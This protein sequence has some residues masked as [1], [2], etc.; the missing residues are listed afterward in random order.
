MYNEGRL[1][2]STLLSSSF[3]T[4]EASKQLPHMDKKL[5]L[6]PQPGPDFHSTKA[7]HQQKI[8]DQAK[9]L[10]KFIQDAYIE[11]GYTQDPYMKEKYNETKEAE[12]SL[13][14][15]VVQM[16]SFIHDTHFDA[17]GFEKDFDRISRNFADI[18]GS[19]RGAGEHNL[20]LEAQLS[21][22]TRMFLSMQFAMKNMKSHD[23]F[24]TTAD[25]LINYMMDLNVRLLGLYDGHGNLDTG[26][27]GYRNKLL[28][29]WRNMYRWTDH[30]RSLKNVPESKKK[31]FEEERSAAEIFVA[32]LWNQVPWNGAELSLQSQGNMSVGYIDV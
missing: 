22:T 29:F 1:I 17:A 30:F 4:G 16:Q 9:A 32:D 3:L 21:F 18:S 5:D 25:A 7:A 10:A 12:E 23:I 27:S 24:V 19:A 2:A 13:S 20:K 6:T 11:A 14:W 8:S 28:E 31:S 26:N 15:L